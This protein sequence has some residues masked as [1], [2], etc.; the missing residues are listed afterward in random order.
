MSCSNERLLT[1][2][3]TKWMP[4]EGHE[5]LVFKSNSGEMDTIFIIGKDTVLSYVEPQSINGITYEV[6]NVY[7]KH[8]DN[9]VDDSSRSY[10]DGVFLELRKAKDGKAELYPLITAKGS[11]LYL[12]N[13]IKI[14]FLNKQKPVLLS[15]QGYPNIEVYKITSDAESLYGDRKG[16]ISTFYWSRT[17]GLIR[18]DRKDGVYWELIKKY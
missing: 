15:T 6:V 5:T 2:D 4:Y 12:Q 7:G 3:D 18:F 13:P 16:F 1:A 10:T 8:F 9:S 11:R 14:E 17:Q